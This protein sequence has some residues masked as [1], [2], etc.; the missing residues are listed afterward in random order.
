LTSN[1]DCGF[2]S[3]VGT[4]A[5]A[6]YYQWSV[7]ACA[8]ID[9][10]VMAVFNNTLRPLEHM[11]PPGAP[12]DPAR[13]ER[14]R[15]EFGQRTEAVSAALTGRTYLLESGFLG[16]DILIGHSCSMA[17]HTGLLGDFSVL[18]F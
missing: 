8:E 7:F 17:M 15:A 1:P 2:A 12:H 9:P 13:A 3:A 18:E 16:V 14:G 5:R 4:P 10:P 11:H 6:Y